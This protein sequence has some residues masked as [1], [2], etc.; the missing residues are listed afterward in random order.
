MKKFLLVAVAAL[1]MLMTS[2]GGGLKV[3]MD[4]PTNETITVKID[5]D[6]EYTLS[7]MQL[8]EV[9]GLKAGDHTMTVNGGPEIKFN[10]AGSSL[11]NPTLSTYV[12]DKQEY[13]STSGNMDT[14]DWVDI[15]IDGEEY[16]GPIEA[17]EN[18][19]I[20]SL[21]KI[22]Y[23]VLVDFPDEVETSRGSVTHTK[24]FRGVDYPKYYKAAYN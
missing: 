9:K 17:F 6:K 24:L 21:E 11:L 2:C 1:A 3:E 14:S 18:Q 16:W 19:P 20:I 4:N 12:T 8:M 23:G 5:G 13:S 22:N 15:V 7:P 10:L